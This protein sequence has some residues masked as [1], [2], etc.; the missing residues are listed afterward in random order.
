MKKEKGKLV[1]CILI[2]IIAIAIVLTVLLWLGGRKNVDIVPA[3]ELSVQKPDVVIKEVEKFVEIEKQI[4]AE[5]IQDGL[6]DMGVLITEEYYFTEVVSF[7]SVKNLFKTEIALPFTE[8]SYL[9][10]YDGVVTAGIDFTQI[11]IAKD[12]SLGLIT[13]TLPKAGVQN[14]D[15]DPESFILYSEKEGLGNPFSINDF[16]M[17]LIDLENKA[18]SKAIERGLLTRADENAKSVISNFIG[19]ITDASKYK[20]EFMYK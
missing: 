16:N 19:S 20:V 17:S 11:E 2:A 12:D 8:S 13:V 5:V 6:K 3:P 9:A 15:I 4:T 1:Y 18:E 7:S 14:V 10:S